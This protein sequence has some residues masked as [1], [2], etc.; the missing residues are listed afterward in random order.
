MHFRNALNDVLASIQAGC[1]DADDSTEYMLQQM[2]DA[3]ERFNYTNETD[4][5]PHE[6]IMNFLGMDQLHG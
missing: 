4:F 5:D 2:R 6:T 3:V 1:D